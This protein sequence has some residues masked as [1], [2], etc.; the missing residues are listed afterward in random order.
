M[1]IVRFDIL[2]KS[3]QKNEEI[4]SENLHTRSL[5]TPKRRRGKSS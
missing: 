4:R 1:P 2:R 5:A 3:K